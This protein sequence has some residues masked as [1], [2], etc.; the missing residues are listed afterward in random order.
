M[1]GIRQR[2][3]NGEEKSAMKESHRKIG[4]KNGGEEAVMKKQL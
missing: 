3:D 4:D 1:T 2:G